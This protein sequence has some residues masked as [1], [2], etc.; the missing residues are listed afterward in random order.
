YKMNGAELGR[1]TGVE[2]PLELDEARAKAVE[3]SGGTG[4]P[5]F[6][7]LSE[8][9]ILAANSGRV[10]HVAALP[11]RG[12]IDIVGAGDSV[13]AGLASALAA[14]A[15]LRESLELASLASSLVIH[16]LGT[17]GTATPQQMLE[18]LQESALLEA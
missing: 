7:T 13:T 9:G 8:N 11:T 15:S 4:K 6:V 3:L 14:G 16:Q 10:E 5:V 1:L 12:A 17:T 2:R 18:L